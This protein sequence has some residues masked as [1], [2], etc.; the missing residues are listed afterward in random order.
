MTLCF[1]T[2]QV[3][4]DTFF[5]CVALTAASLQ[6]WHW[7]LF[8]QSANKIVNGNHDGV[9]E[10]AYRVPAACPEFCRAENG[11]CHRCGGTEPPAVGSATSFCPQT[12][13]IRLNDDG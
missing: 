1:C 5:G 8:K 9:L 12:G 2:G 10:N 4:Q 6:K 7:R 13:E 3:K 11:G